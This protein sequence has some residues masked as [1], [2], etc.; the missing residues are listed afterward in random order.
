[1][2]DSPRFR[3]LRAWLG[4]LGLFVLALVLVWASFA[5]GKTRL[6]YQVAADLIEQF[7]DGIWV[8][9]LAALTDAELVKR[10]QPRFLNGNEV[11][12]ICK[13]KEGA[14]GESP[15]P[16]SGKRGHPLK[17]NEGSVSG[18]RAVF[19]FALVP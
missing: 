19:G 1:M 9:E 7:P 15:L 16:G 18:Y 10:L 6:A 12:G 11:R 2:A 5:C 17:A 8:V 3:A 13:Q 4:R 14:M